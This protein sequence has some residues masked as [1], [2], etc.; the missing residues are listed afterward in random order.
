MENP[1]SKANHPEV[2]PPKVTLS[3]VGLKLEGLDFVEEVSLFG[4]FLSRA[5]ARSKKRTTAIGAELGVSSDVIKA[6][7]DAKYVP[8]VDIVPAIAESFQ[9]DLEELMKAFQISFAAIA[10]EKKLRRPPAKAR[11]PDYSL[12]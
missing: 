12:D 3:S 1:I 11:K 8:S 6:W 7:R 4:D 2:I 5:L 9:I 10:K